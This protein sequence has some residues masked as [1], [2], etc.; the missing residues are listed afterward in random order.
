M[1]IPL[2]SLEEQDEVAKEYIKTLERI[3]KI[4]EELEKEKLHLKQIFK[5]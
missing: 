4:K 2:P 5:E 3:K 1:V